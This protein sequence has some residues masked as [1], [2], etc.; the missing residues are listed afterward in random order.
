M[1]PWDRPDLELDERT[2]LVLCEIQYRLKG[3]GR[4]LLLIVALG[5]LVLMAAGI[6]A[7]R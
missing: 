4:M 5:F 2:F 3:L 1:N 6:S 7:N